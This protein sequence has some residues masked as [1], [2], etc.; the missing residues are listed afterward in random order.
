LLCG[1]LPTDM[2]TFVAVS[3]VLTAAALLARYVLARRAAKVD[4]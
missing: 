3:L 4:P 1:V 2:L